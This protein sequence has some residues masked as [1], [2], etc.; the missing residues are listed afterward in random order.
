MVHTNQ[1]IVITY[2]SQTS[3]IIGG[4]AHITKILGKKVNG[5]VIGAHNNKKLIVKV[6]E[7][8]DT[9]AAKEHFG[10]KKTKWYKDDWDTEIKLVKFKGKD[11]SLHAERELIRLIDVYIRNQQ[12]DPI[13]Y[14][15]NGLGFNSNTWVQTAIELA[16][17]KIEGGGD[18]KGF[19][20]SNKK[21][22]PKTYFEAYCPEKP[23]IKLNEE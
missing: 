15:D 3:E 20:V 12:L 11:F 13:K 6:F 8:A 2:P 4:R 17:G 9:E 21:R 22:I 5:L 16:G 10:G 18:M 23:R 14:P 1:F 19:D 7:E